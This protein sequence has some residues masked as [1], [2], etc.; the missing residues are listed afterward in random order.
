[1]QHFEAQPLGRGATVL[2][3]SWLASSGTFTGTSPRCLGVG[4]IDGAHNELVGRS[5]CRP[6]DPGPPQQ[7]MIQGKSGRPMC[8]STLHGFRSNFGSSDVAGLSSDVQMISNP[9][10]CI[11]DSGDH[12]R[13]EGAGAAASASS[14]PPAIVAA[15]TSTACCRKR[16]EGRDLITEAVVSSLKAVQAMRRQVHGDS[17]DDAKTATGRPRS[18][19]PRQ[20]LRDT[21]GRVV[22]NPTVEWHIHQIERVINMIEY[23]GERILFYSQD[24]QQHP[25]MFDMVEEDVRDIHAELTTM[26]AALERDQPASV[27]RPVSHGL[28]TMP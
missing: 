27:Q 12:L 15:T 10:V 20:A 9:S 13:N 7:N 4:K 5:C 25:T 1:M 17:G 3:T 28:Q 19:S 26:L 8:D 18:R 14:P 11:G 22:V 21:R 2:Q 23:L 6:A 24:Q 16:E